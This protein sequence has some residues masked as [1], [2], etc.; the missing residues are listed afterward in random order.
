[1]EV[2]VATD[3]GERSDPVIRARL[4][5][6]ALRASVLT[7]IA[8]G[9]RREIREPKSRLEMTCVLGRPTMK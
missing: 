1:M 5:G 3:A 2:Q 4:A 7:P 8:S 9:D 6:A